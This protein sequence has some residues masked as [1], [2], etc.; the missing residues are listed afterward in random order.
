MNRRPSASVPGAVRSQ[1]VAPGYPAR[2]PQAHRA[3]I[4]RRLVRDEA[5]WLIDERLRDPVSSDLIQNPAQSKNL[6]L[7][8]DYTSR[9]TF[10]LVCVWRFRNSMRG[11]PA[12]SATG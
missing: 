3:G 8:F 7:P 5:C 11:Y 1:A 2:K 12:A 9:A 6:Q 4:V 10:Q